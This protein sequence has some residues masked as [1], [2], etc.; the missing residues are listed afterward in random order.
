[1]KKIAIFPNLGKAEVRQAL[2]GLCNYIDRRG[3]QPLLPAECE[4]VAGCQQYC[5]RDEYFLLSAELG[6][7]LG[8]DGTVINNARRLV[9]G[10]VPFCGVNYGRLGFLAEIEP[11]EIQTAVDRML[12]GQYEVVER[13]MLAA[14]V[15]RCGDT[16]FRET[17]LN[18]VVISKGSTA[19]LI[20]LDL[21]VDQAFTERYPCDGLVMA[22]PVG[23]TAYSLSAGGPIV[24]NHLSLII[25]T[26]ICPHTLHNRSLIISRDETATVEID[27]GHDDI[28]L[29]LDGQISQ[30]LR[31]GDRIVVR[32]ADR[33]AR[34]VRFADRKNYYE[35]LR[36]KLW[37]YEGR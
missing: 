4:A 5:Q 9:A 15:E 25:I 19:R 24:S 33:P 30:A 37:R 26:P 3:G 8:G 7:T 2:P 13:M 22:T 28:I 10:G 14:A 29:S 12:A 35:T 31:S 34:F 21:F 17:A 36:A 6:L 20:R 27:S 18:D 1:M 23:S 16:V 32:T 11:Q